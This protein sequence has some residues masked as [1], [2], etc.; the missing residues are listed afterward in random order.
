MKIGIMIAMAAIVGQ[1]LMRS[2]AA[3]RIV[4]AIRNF[5]GEKNAPIAFIAS[6]FTLGIPVFFETVFYLLMPLG[7]AM[8]LKTGRNYLLYILTII[9]GG[10]MAHSLVPPTPG[11]L[12][13]AYELGV[14][15]GLAIICGTI[16]GIFTTS[17]GYLWARFISKR[18]TIPLRDSEDLSKSRLEEM[19][20]RS[21]DELP[22]LLASIL[23][24]LIPLFFTCWGN[25][26]QSFIK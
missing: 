10:S 12:F 1:C 23:P 21:E 6:G 9:A 16:V 5:L 2:G 22:S 11:P 3:E 17:A 24:I 19:A 25:D 26:F 7:R 18:I 13:V 14:D 20:Q 4:L 8:H 15:I